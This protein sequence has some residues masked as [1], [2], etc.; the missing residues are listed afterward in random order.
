MTWR[1]VA[2][3]LREGRLLGDLKASSF[4]VTDQLND[5]GSWTMDVVVDVDMGT[6]PTVARL[7][8]RGKV[9][10]LSLRDDMPA[11]FGIV[12]A[13]NY[14]LGSGVLQLAGAG[15]S[16]YLHRRL[17]PDAAAVATL[18]TAIIADLVAH[19]N[20]TDGIGIQVATSGGRARDRSWLLQDA[21]NLGEAIAEL[22]QVRAGPDV[23]TEFTVT[24]AG[25]ER[26]L[27]VWSP[28][29]GRRLDEATSPRFEHGVNAWDGTIAGD[30]A[31]IAFY[32]LATGEGDAAA[33]VYAEASNL[34]VLS[35][36]DAPR[37]DAHIDR[38]TVRN[39]TTLRDAAEGHLDRSDGTRIEPCTVV[40][41]PSHTHAAWGTWRVGDDAYL[42]A[43]ANDPLW[44]GK[45][46][47]RRITATQW[48]VSDTA[49]T[50]QVTLGPIELDPPPD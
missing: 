4:D 13:S 37:L 3:T 41:D 43:A 27:R 19:T 10:V 25:V 38:S 1:H 47:E 18:D 12:W 31:D 2:Y 32:V 5:V 22:T 29:A 7:L 39:V 20:N 17:I 35:Y 21:K 8:E 16:S 26:F 36:T 14:L 9:A 28:R 15:L 11:A 30:A 50:L 23:T 34:A 33:K 6:P 44:P 46:W 45:V 42:I 24:A 49:E 48:Q 40:V